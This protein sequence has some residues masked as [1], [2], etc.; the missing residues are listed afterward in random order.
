[1]LTFFWYDYKPSRFESIINRS[2][3]LGLKPVLGVV[4]WLNF[5]KVFM[6][7]SL[8]NWSFLLVNCLYAAADE[9]Y[10]LRHHLIRSGCHLIPLLSFFLAGSFCCCRSNHCG[11]SGSKVHSAEYMI[12]ASPSWCTSSIC[13]PSLGITL[14]IITDILATFTR[15]S[16]F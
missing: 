13:S 2:I 14:L 5:F 12:Y 1:M 3:I 6:W 7:S 11:V 15:A 9:W 8:M 16:L 10:M 4:N